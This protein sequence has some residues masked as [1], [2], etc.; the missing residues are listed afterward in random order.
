[1]PS[2][3]FYLNVVICFCI[4]T[5][6]MIPPYSYHCDQD[7]YPHICDMHD[8]H[9]C[10]HAKTPVASFSPQGVQIT[11]NRLFFHLKIAVVLTL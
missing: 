5:V 6:G 1:M 11:V 8:D 4:S 2:F 9:F 7:F 10:D 3:W